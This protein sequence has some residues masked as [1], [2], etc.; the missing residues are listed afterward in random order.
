MFCCA[1]ARC[2]E[3]KIVPELLHQ[4]LRDNTINCDGHRV[5]QPSLGL[6]INLHLESLFEFSFEL[7]SKGTNPFP[8][9]FY[10]L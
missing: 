10:V 9:T 3:A 8:V 7:I 2:G 4:C 6:P 1:G 5:G